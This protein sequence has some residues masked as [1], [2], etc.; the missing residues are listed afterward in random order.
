MFAGTQDKCVACSKTVYPI[1]KVLIL[2]PK[3]K[4]LNPH[5]LGLTWLMT[6]ALTGGSRWQL[7]SQGLFQVQPWRLHDKPI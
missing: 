5:Q 6:C 7:V 2:I 4:I 1:E 3:I